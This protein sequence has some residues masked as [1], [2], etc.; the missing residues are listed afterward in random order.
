[1]SAIPK[2]KMQSWS[3]SLLTLDDRINRSSNNEHRQLRSPPKPRATQ[4]LKT[5]RMGDPIQ[6]HAIDS[7]DWNR[8]PS[9]QYMST[10]EAQN[11]MLATAGLTR[12]IESIQK[13]SQQMPTAF[14]DYEQP[15]IA[16]KTRAD[17]TDTDAERR[18]V[19]SISN[20]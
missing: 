16:A 3:R 7:S 5:I 12:Q 20:Y 6:A 9:E 19:H 17:I 2:P 11:L 1:M 10:Q 15:Y 14:Y 18:A 4:S 8:D 13:A